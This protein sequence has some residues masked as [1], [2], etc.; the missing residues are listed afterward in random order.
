MEKWFERAF[1]F[2]LLKYDFVEIG[3]MEINIV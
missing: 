1:M 3:Y 2:A